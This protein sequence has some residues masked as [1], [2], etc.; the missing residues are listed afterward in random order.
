MTATAGEMPSALESI[1]ADNLP[2]AQSEQLRIRNQFSPH[3]K[4]DTK[5]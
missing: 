3:P 2:P 5:S 1:D 4:A